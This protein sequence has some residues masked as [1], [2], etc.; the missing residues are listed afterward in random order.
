MSDTKKTVRNRK[1]NRSY[2][3]R[4]AKRQESLQ[5]YAMITP[6]LIGFLV[7]SLYPLFWVLRYVFYEYDGVN[8]SFVGLENLIRAFGD[9]AYW[10]TVVNTFII[11]F[12]KLIIELPLALLLAVILNESVRG[13]SAFRLI[14]F[15]P[16]IISVAIVGIVFSYMFSTFDGIVN[17]FLINIGCIS[18]PI[19]WFANRWT[20]NIVIMIAS[21]WNSFGVNMI[22]FLS[23]LLNIPRELYESG[24][25][26]GANKWQQFCHITFPQ[27]ASV[28]QIIL[29]LAITGGIKM[30]DI[31]LTLTNG[32]PGG[33]TEVVMSYLYKQ[34]FG[35]EGVSQQIGYA[36]ALGLVTSV[37]IGLITIVYLRVSKKATTIND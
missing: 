10:R 28:S 9:V 35:G 1:N 4:Q 7:F 29:M 11:S 36:C 6:Q 37:I 20:A 2:G 22:Y 17:N 3:V 15:M 23:G 32:Q 24:S 30:N 13:K 19:D 25:I 21:T 12:G 14:F 26:D 18:E 16:N 8:E 33:E 5:S 34:F 27:L 31:V